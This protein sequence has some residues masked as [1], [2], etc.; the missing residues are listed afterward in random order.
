MRAAP[1][2]RDPRR[3]RRSTIGS[4]SSASRNQIPIRFAFLHASV[5]IFALLFVALTNYCFRQLCFYAVLL[6][7]ETHNNTL[8]LRAAHSDKLN[9]CSQPGFA[10]WVSNNFARNL[11]IFC[12]FQWIH[13]SG[14]DEG[15][16]GVQKGTGQKSQGTEKA[17]PLLPK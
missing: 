4:P 12:G 3:R 1:P 8:P 11:I 16:P 17:S 13:R 14:N 2:H 6:L 7:G 9:I 5:S 10:G 15:H